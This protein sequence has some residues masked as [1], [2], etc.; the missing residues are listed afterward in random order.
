MENL[1]IHSFK[2]G[3][4]ELLSTLKELNFPNHKI[5][6]IGDCQLKLLIFKNL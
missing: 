6:N 2:I 1:R 3:I 5:L 4:K